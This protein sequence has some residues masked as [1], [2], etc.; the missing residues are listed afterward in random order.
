MPASRFEFW[1]VTV[2]DFDHEQEDVLVKINE[3]EFRR[4]FND[5]Y[6]LML[7]R[8]VNSSGPFRGKK[9]TPKE[10]QEFADRVLVQTV[11]NMRRIANARNVP[12]LKNYYGNSKAD[13]SRA[14]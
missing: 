13:E 7:N 1:L 10:G 9:M 5:E 12:G 3:T 14:G 6:E 8:K 2:H 4:E 11:G